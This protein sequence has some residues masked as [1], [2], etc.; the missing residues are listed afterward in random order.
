MCILIIAWFFGFFSF[1]F[2]S[3]SCHRS[4]RTFLTRAGGETRNTYV[5][6]YG[7]ES[8]RYD[9]K[10]YGR[11][12]KY[13]LGQQGLHVRNTEYA[14]YIPRPWTGQVSAFVNSTGWL[15]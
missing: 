2:S 5:L 11:Y 15:A 14:E 10:V 6:A 8:I 4:R 7:G 13:V 9:R 1:L 3:F 12:T